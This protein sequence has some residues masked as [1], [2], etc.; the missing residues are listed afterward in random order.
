MAASLP[1]PTPKEFGVR[2]NAVSFLP[3]AFLVLFFLLLVG[4]GPPFE[5]PSIKHLV[6]PVRSLN[7]AQLVAASIL[8]IAVGLVAQPL[9]LPL[10]R[11]LEGYHWNSTRLGYVFHAAKVE[12][13]WRRQ[14]RLRAI[15]SQ[16][17]PL[18]SFGPWLTPWE[19]RRT[20]RRRR[21]RQSGEALAATDQLIWYPEGNL[22]PTRLGNTLR[23][24]EL[25]AGERYGLNTIESW[26]RLFP[27]LSPRL[28]EVITDLRNQVDTSARF[29]VVFAIATVGSAALLAVHG[30]W[31]LIPALMFISSWVA[32]RAAINAAV[33]YGRQLHVAFDLHRFDMLRALDLPLPPDPT[34][35]RQ[36]NQYLSQFFQYGLVDP[37]A[38]MPAVHYQHR[39]DGQ[40]S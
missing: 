1:D 33:A 9:Q 7:I 38:R 34:I 27:H 25:R 3:T 6:S 19:R 16:T 13:Q 21:L 37:A 23:S 18:P 15:S 17:A 40:S 11:V 29:C 10:V 30:P 12:L 5:D 36:W 28:G 26:P 4:L 24:A 31:L 22:L 35:E 20:A 14:E 39:P 2:F 8:I 32:Y